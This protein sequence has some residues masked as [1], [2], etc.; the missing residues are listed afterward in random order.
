MLNFKLYKPTALEDWINNKY[1]DEKI[2]RPSLLDIEHIA[3][4]FNVEVAT[5][6]VASHVFWEENYCVIFLN[7]FCSESKRRADFFHELCHPLQHSGDQRSMPDAY[8]ELQEIQANLFQLYA[9]LPLPLLADID[10]P[11]SVFEK[12]VAEEFNLPPKLV[13]R[14]LEQIQNRITAAKINLHTQMRFNQ[15]QNYKKAV[16]YDFMI[17][18]D[19]GALLMSHTKGTLGYIR[20]QED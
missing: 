18:G 19:R 6:K 8:R 2:I 5:T 10:A 4:L 11:S 1:Q 13:H 3:S 20:Y 17:R 9:A 7:A 14:R 15:E 16:G 12:V